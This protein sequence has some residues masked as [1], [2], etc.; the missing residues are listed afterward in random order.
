M[1]RK[2]R[3]ILTRIIEVAV[4]L[5]LSGM[6][7]LQSPGVQTRIAQDVVDRLES[8]I[9]ADISFSGIKFAPF[10]TLIIKDLAIVDKHP[11]HP[12]DTLISAKHISATFTLRGLLAKKGGV[13][14][15][16][17][18]TE[19]FCL[20]LILYDQRESDG[21][22]NNFESI[23]GVPDPNVPKKPVE[24]LFSIRRVHLDNFRYRMINLTS[25]ENHW[26]G[27]GINW[28]D[29][30]LTADARGRNINFVDGRCSFHVD[31]IRVKEKCGY[32]MTAMGDCITGRGKTE[33]TDARIRDQWSDIQLKSYT[34]DFGVMKNFEDFLHKVSL[35][36][37]ATASPLGIKT[38][39]Y[40]SGILADCPLSLDLKDLKVNGPV[41]DMQIESLI[42]TD[43][44][45]G[46]TADLNAG[47]QDIFTLQ[48]A[49]AR[50]ESRRFEFTPESLGKF[51]NGIVPDLKLDISKFAAGAKANLTCN[52]EGPLNGLSAQLNLNSNMG[53][54]SLTGKIDNLVQPDKAMG[55]QVSLALLELDLG[56]LGL[57]D[58][59]GKSTLKLVSHGSIDNGKPDI[60][61]DTL[62]IRK[63]TLMDYAYTGIDGT[64]VFKN[65]TFTGNIRCHDPNLDFILGGSFSLSEKSGKSIYKF[66]LSLPYAD[67]AAIKLDKREG[68]SRLATSMNINLRT[69]SKGIFLGDA[70]IYRLT[71]T[72]DDGKH[73][74]GD[75]RFMSVLDQERIRINLKSSFADVSYSG[76]PDLGTILDPLLACTAFNSLPALFHDNIPKW[77]GRTF[78]AS[79]QIKDTKE[80][81]AFLHQDIYI[82]PGTSAKLSLKS[83]STV[84]ANFSSDGIRY[85]TSVLK[86]LTAS[87]STL[88]N[89][90]KAAIHIKSLSANGSSIKDFDIQANAQDNNADILLSLRDALNKDIDAD[91]DI[92]GTFRRGND[93][94]L[95]L[96]AGMDNSRLQMGDDVWTFSK[97]RITWENSTINFSDFTIANGVQTIS[98][99]G[100][101]SEKIPSELTLILTS[102]DLG[103]INHFTETDMDLKGILGG[104]VK[105][106]SPSRTNAGL[107][108]DLLCPELGVRNTSA[109]RLHLTG[110]LDDEDDL[111]KFKADNTHGDGST[112]IKA[113]GNYNAVSRFINARLNLNDFNPDII[114]PALA[115]VISELS[116]AINGR[117]TVTGSLDKPDIRCKDLTIKNTRVGLVPTGVTYSLNGNLSYDSHGLSVERLDIQDGNGGNAVLSGL[118]PD[119]T[120]NLYHLDVLD[121]HSGGRNYYGDLAV[122]GEVRMRQT[123]SNL[124]VEANISNAGAGKINISLADINENAGTLLQFKKAGPKEVDM[125]LS[126]ATPQEDKMTPLKLEAK[127]RLNVTPGL[128][129]VA[130]LDKEGSNSLNISG[131]GAITADLNPT[132]GA[133]SLGGTYNIT[134]GKYHFSAL[135]SLISKDF[136]INDGS[137]VTF[138]GDL[139]DTE[140]NIDATHTLKASIGTL[141]ADT[142]AIANRRTVNC[143]IAISDKIRNPGLSFSI[144]VPDLDPTTKS[145]VDSELNTEDKVNRQF[146][147]LVVLGNFLPSE[148]AGIVNSTSNSNF[149]L[150][151][152]TG[153]MSGSLNSVLQ[154]F[155]IP[156]DLDLSY[157]QSQVG[158]DVVD[159]G[160]STQLFDNM[161]QVSGS[162]GNRKFNSTSDESVVGDLDISIKLNRSGHFKF[163]IFSH[164]ADDYTNF[165]DNS[166]RNG[167]GVSYQKEY[168]NFWT[169]ITGIFRKKEEQKQEAVP[170][171]RIV[172]KNE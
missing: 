77:D 172:I 31:F 48:D 38:I 45:S 14:I 30:D 20:N 46:I 119:I 63:L 117:V 114:Q 44:W 100:G 115:D 89:S 41:D 71:Y 118:V 99:N 6:L 171:K 43:N 120:L 82:A 154:K 58:T 159:V 61:L 68:T 67:L 105:Y 37:N 149:A 134:D 136:N 53:E 13:H 80:A 79:V 49:K 107:M 35:G 15:D 143:G 128:E 26:S 165:L 4:L 55:Y 62:A 85:G 81:L 152:L 34:M 22:H 33:V 144:D 54:A 19:D 21:A 70:G 5:V 42:F 28:F 163:N 56:K 102:I 108:V 111:I 90:T 101:L 59:F 69:T 52:V 150:S 73:S 97:P 138:N 104:Y 133:L 93:G 64:G 11:E 130:N 146:L 123:Q 23:F 50:L 155:N 1:R 131:E 145:L 142:T 51:I 166:Q 3:I 57:G 113:E 112:V 110:H 162:V 39:S 88:E 169:F 141:I 18:R 135:G 36:G 98:I 151:S 170:T 17:L 83:N 158:N 75:I 29:L 9:N 124:S 121:K 7:L 126:V 86:N 116:G 74:I 95:Q 129:L 109:G 153:L 103:L 16:R 32:E 84:Q 72:D 2:T 65:N 127:C 168:D 92:N 147:A 122:N 10:T 164:S 40:F 66:N 94:E 157:Q 137:T 76:D 47:V 160:L 78:E 140:L 12:L 156:L 167:V 25:A 60:S 24:D 161:V 96:L 132:S 125:N 139:M 106:S 148:Q 91:I 8:N 87:L 27:H